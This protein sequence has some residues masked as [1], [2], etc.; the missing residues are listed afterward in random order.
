MKIADFRSKTGIL[1]LQ[2]KIRRPAAGG[3][4]G[5]HAKGSCE[6][7]QSRKEAAIS[8]A[9]LCSGSASFG[10]LPR[11]LFLH[12]AEAPSRKRHVGC[13]DVNQWLDTMAK[14]KVTAPPAAEVP[15]DNP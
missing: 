11:A 1:H 12:Q 10:H 8:N 7:G 2:S 13:R 5:T 6:P 3:W 4:K 14:R 9:P 15:A